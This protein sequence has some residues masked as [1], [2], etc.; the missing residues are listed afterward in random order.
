MIHIA[1]TYWTDSRWI[2]IQSRY[3]NAHLSEEFRVYAFLNHINDA[4][5]YRAK[6]FF[7]STE[8][9]DSHATKLNLLAD[10]MMSH[11]QSDEDLMMFIDGD[12][13]PIGDVVPF[14]RGALAECP[15]LAIQRLENNG[16]MQPHPCFCMTTVGFWKQLG[17]DWKSGYEWKDAQGK[18][19]TDVGGNLLGQLEKGGFRWLPLHRSNRVNLHPLWFGVYRDLVYHHG[20]SFREHQ[21]SRLDLHEIGDL[22]TLPHLRRIETKVLGRLNRH[23]KLD[24]LERLSPIRQRFDAKV[25]DNRKIIS[26]MFHALEQDPRFF[27]RLIGSGARASERAVNEPSFPSGAEKQEGSNSIGVTKVRCTLPAPGLAGDVA[28]PAG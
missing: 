28:R 15:L 13:L 21:W 12:A 8:L 23:L 4:A 27:E 17:G 10:V 20:A 2:N 18:L 22:S 1:A 14:A 6:F 24:W 7:L 25:E 26:E 5:D 9:I 11:S 3:F 19:V 16:D